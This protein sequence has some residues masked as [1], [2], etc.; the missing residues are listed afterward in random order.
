MQHH[1]WDD[2]HCQGF[3]E[4]QLHH[5]WD[6]STALTLWP[7]CGQSEGEDCKHPICETCMASFVTARVE[8]RMVFGIRC[9]FEGCK[10]LVYEQDV[11]KLVTRGLVP[12]AIAEQ[13][14]KLRHQNYADRHVELEDGL[15]SSEDAEVLETLWA[16]TKRC[17]SCSVIIERS[18]G[19]DSFGC[20]C[21]HRFDYAEAPRG[22]G[23]GI[24][25]FSNITHLAAEHEIPLK[26]SMALVQE[27]S[28]RGIHDFDPVTDLSSQHKLPVQDAMDIV[29]EGLKKGIQ[30]YGSVLAQAEKLHAP[31]SLAEAYVQAHLGQDVDIKQVRDGNFKQKLGRK[32]EKEVRKARR[33]RCLSL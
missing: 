21:G 7:E 18:A 19:C 10:Q 15:L 20:I 3:I 2:L 22:F 9:P 6:H 4:A 33:L 27:G 14:A 13:M 11:Q 28:K 30:N 32:I 31:L 26:D 17:P 1:R 8:E 5:S 12:S 24:H 29:E 23:D 25:K 16:T